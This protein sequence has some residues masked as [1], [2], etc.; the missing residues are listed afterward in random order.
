MSRLEKHFGAGSGA[1]SASSWDGAG[2][3]ADSASSWDGAGSGHSGEVLFE[4]AVLP[5]LQ[6]TEALAVLLG[7]PAD[8]LEDG[9][10]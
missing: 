8:P 4:P 1:D 9:S 2:S 6:R 10:L 5:Q 7:A 3:G